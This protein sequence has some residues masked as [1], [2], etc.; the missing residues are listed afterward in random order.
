MPAEQYEWNS[1][2]CVMFKAADGTS[3]IIS[4]INNI[5]STDETGVDIIDSVDGCN[6][7][8]SFLN[9]RYTFNME[10]QALNFSVHRK[11]VTVAKT[12]TKFSIGWCTVSGS[13]DD[14]LL[15]SMEFTDCVITSMVHSIASDNKVPI[16]KFAASCL[17]NSVSNNGE[18]VVTDKVGRA[19]GSLS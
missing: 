4:P 3:T 5:E 7:G 10:V 18:V 14:W 13:S 2:L 1:R 9:P 11:L 6:L 17:G 16:I 19:S 12:R 15:D 8:F